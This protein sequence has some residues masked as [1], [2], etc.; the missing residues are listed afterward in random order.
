MLLLG[1]FSGTND[2]IQNLIEIPL[3]F[4]HQ[5]KKVPKKQIL[6]KFNIEKNV[7]SIYG[8]SLFVWV[9]FLVISHFK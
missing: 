4:N 9:F 6:G 3:S 2:F 8:Q 7:Y 1:K 5:N